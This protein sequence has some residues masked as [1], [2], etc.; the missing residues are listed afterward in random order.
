VFPKPGRYLV[1]V[2]FPQGQAA[3]ES[4]EINVESRGDGPLAN[5]R[6]Q[7]FIAKGASRRSPL[8][9]RRLDEA[10]ADVAHLDPTSRGYLA[11]IRT[12]TERD[13]SRAAALHK[14]ALADKSPTA[15]RH[16]AVIAQ[17]K[18]LVRDGALN[19]AAWLRVKE[20]HLRR[21][22]DQ[23]LIEQLEEFQSW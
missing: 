18:A 19:K 20:R 1:S 21:E 7:R 10:L 3:A 9:L 22:E 12:Y 13:P 23:Y 8:F 2:V 6:F 17:V 14:I 4:V 5:L 16:A 15:V 11:L